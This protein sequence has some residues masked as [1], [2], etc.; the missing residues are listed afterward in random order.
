MATI[1]GFGSTQISYA[2]S[3]YQFLGIIGGIA[4][5]FLFYKIQAYN[6]VITV[7]LSASVVCKLLFIFN[8]FECSQYPK[9]YFVTEAK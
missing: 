9:L 7:L 1:Y 6:L 8:I 5:S 2:G 3:L 4:L